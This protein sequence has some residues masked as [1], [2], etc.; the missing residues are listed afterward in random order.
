MSEVTGTIGSEHVELNN[1]ATEATLKL[2]LVAMKASSK[3]AAAAVDKIAQNAGIDPN[4]IKKLNEELEHT[5][6]AAYRL[7]AAYGKASNIA[8]SISDV[9]QNFTPVVKT[10]TSGTG[11]VGTAFK[12]IGDQIPG[13]LGQIMKGLGAVASIQQEYYKTYQDLSK[14]GINFGGSLTDMRMAA[15]ESFMAL[16]DFSKLLQ[17]NKENFVRFGGSVNGGAVAFSKFS[18]SILDSEVGDHLRALGFSAEE[19]NQGM[20]TY[21]SA[22]GISNKKDLESNQQLR[23]GAAQYLEELDRLAEVTGKS[24]KEQDDLMKKQ[25]LDADIQMTAARMPAKERAA[26]EANV[27]YMTMMYGDA[28]KDMALAQAQ[29]RNVVTQ[30]GKML[31]SLA[32]QAQEIYAKMSKAQLGSAEYI[33]YQNQ[34]SLAIQGGINQVDTRT[35]SVSKSFDSIRD[36]VLTS[37]NQM[38][39]GLT[40]EEKLSERDREIQAEKI[41]RDTSQADEAGKAQVAI[42]KLGNS[43]LSILLPVFETLASITSFVAE[44]LN[45]T[46]GKIGLLAGAITIAVGLLVTKNKLEAAG[47]VSGM[48][49]KIPGLGGLGKNVGKAEGIADKI[50]GAGSGKGS[51][52]GGVLE[53]LALGLKAFGTGAPQIILGAGALAASIA[54]IGAGI[55]A[56]SWLMGKALPTL[57]EGLDQIAK[58]DG[59]NLIKVGG[60]MI[61][62][63]AGLASFGAGQAFASFGNVLGG[64]ANGL[65]SLVGIDTPMEKLAKFAKLGPGLKEAGEGMQ[66]IN[67]NLSN[68]LTLKVGDIDNLTNS[69]KKIKLSSGTGGTSNSGS[70]TTA[71]AEAQSEKTQDPIASLAHIA[72]EMKTLNIRTLDVIKYVRETADYAKQNVDATKNLSGDLF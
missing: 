40:S 21:L 68:L 72:A 3:E 53:G 54:L 37:A 18:H 24:R 8:D 4:T 52:A 28:G 60:G 15:A 29:G 38:Q 61:A 67:K 58:V 63:G 69:L 39:A 23:E 30:G 11:D 64:L 12:Q 22:S 56:A 25:K 41:K 55:A 32:P 20:I 9:F 51:L 48:L 59:M 42:Q 7:G 34:L 27:K 1:A 49:S 57:A 36:A 6:S 10:L 2:L 71:G 26:F 50:G 14:A 44:G 5:G 62:L 31:S 13:A 17:E 33:K 65:G 46:I 45:T 35:L 16:G 47:G 66:L 43:L 70:G 19:A